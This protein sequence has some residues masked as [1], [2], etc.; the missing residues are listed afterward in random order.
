MVVNTQEGGDHHLPRTRCSAR[1]KTHSV[2]NEGKVYQSLMMT[3]MTSSQGDVNSSET[4]RHRS[5]QRER[6]QGYR[7]QPPSVANHL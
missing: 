7:Q 5:S 6:T 2:T 4:G 1:G 3:L